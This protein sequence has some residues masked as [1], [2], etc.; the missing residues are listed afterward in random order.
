M[1]MAFFTK[2]GGVLFVRAR[3]HDYG[4]RQNG[5]QG[6]SSHIN[7]ANASILFMFSG[8]GDGFLSITLDGVA[9]G[10]AGF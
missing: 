2:Q 1:G 3:Q 9:S 4:G 6:A 5:N 7:Q 8:T 10:L